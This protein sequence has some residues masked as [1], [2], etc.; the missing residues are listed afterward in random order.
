MN[1]MITFLIFILGLITVIL[2]LVV[3]FKFN[4]YRKHLTGPARKLS[5]A[6]SW[7]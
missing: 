2:S 6:V 1:S 4:T 3:S 7:Q 5:S